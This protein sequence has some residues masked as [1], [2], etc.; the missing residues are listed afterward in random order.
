M[1]APIPFH[2]RPVVLPARA[3]A[4]YGDKSWLMS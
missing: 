4:A 3:W 1:A 2:P